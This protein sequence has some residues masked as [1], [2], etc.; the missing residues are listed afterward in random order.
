[1]STEGLGHNETT[2]ERIEAQNV[3]E[4]VPEGRC[5]PGVPGSGNLGV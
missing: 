5:M 4:G 3:L 1:M 2:I